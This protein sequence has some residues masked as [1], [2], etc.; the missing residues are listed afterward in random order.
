MNFNE[1]GQSAYPT[2][3]LFCISPSAQSV[4][5]FALVVYGVRLSCNSF[6]YFVKIKFQEFG[7]FYIF[8]FYISVAGIS[9]AAVTSQTFYIANEFQCSVSHKL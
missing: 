4:N 8:F 7:G 9:Q 3:L 1:A 2:V 6:V 5:L